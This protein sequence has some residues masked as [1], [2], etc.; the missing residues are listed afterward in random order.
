MSTANNRES[1][2]EGHGGPPAA[3]ID[4]GSQGQQEVAVGESKRA[5]ARGAEEHIRPIGM[6][7]GDNGWGA[8]WAE[9]HGLGGKSGSKGAEDHR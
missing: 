9:E 1:G 7:R 4:N 6:G 5:G 3:G 2:S 8:R